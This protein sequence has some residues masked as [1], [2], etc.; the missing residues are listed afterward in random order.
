MEAIRGYNDMKESLKAFLKKF[1]D[2]GKVVTEEDIQVPI[3]PNT[4]FPI[5]HRFV[6]F[7]YKFVKN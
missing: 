5:L 7:T 3:L 1:A 4:I 6:R 2:E